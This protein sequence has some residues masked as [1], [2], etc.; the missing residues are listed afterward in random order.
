M[1]E[2]R[3]AAK[4]FGDVTA[5]H[6]T[7]LTF[8][9][10]RTTVLI[11]PSGCGKSTILRLLMGL[12]RPD[13]GEVLFDGDPLDPDEALQ[14]RHRMGYVIQGGGLFPHLTARENVELMPDQFA[15]EEER[16]R[17]RVAELV[18]LTHFPEEGLERYPPEL[19]GGQQQRVSLMRALMLD[20]EVLLFDEPLGALDP[21]TRAELQREL[22]EIFE[23]LDKT[24]VWVTHDMDEAAYFGESI[25][26]IRDGRILQKG[27]LRE[28]LEEPAA[29]FVSTFIRAQ[30]STLAEREAESSG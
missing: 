11:G 7:D 1:L 10:G 22:R 23:R 14:I 27:T 24:V 6:P 16:T 15:W 19:S 12:I 21:L 29:D 8:E 13:R 2:L 20:P 5:L 18:E 26:L 9:R 30:R 28:I 3:D 17:E 25:A 4:S